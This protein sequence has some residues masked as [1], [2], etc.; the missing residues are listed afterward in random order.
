MLVLHGHSKHATQQLSDAVIR[1]TIWHE[2]AEMIAKRTGADF[3]FFRHGVAV[4]FV[5]IMRGMTKG[6]IA[7][8]FDAEMGEVWNIEQ[9]LKKHEDQ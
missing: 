3:F 8:R 9:V 7:A 5:E 4:N 2:R 6:E 1:A